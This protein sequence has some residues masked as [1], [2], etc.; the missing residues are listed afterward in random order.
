MTVKQK[1]CLLAYLGYYSASIDGLWG[2]QSAAATKAF[3][4]DFDLTPDEIFGPK[5]ESRIKEVIYKDEQ[6][7]MDWD[8]V[9][10]FRREEFQCHCGGKYCNGY[11]AE[12]KKKLLVVADR[13]REHF[14][15]AALVSSGARCETH[16]KNVGGVTNSRHLVGKAMDFCIRGKTAAEVLEYVQQQPEIRYAY[17]CDSL[18]IHMDIQ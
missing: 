9:K 5:T 1:Q 18:Y 14:G 3:Q 13:V 4:E 17:A 6:P 7:A 12:M 10:Y 11:P 15:A 2:P 16:N 8:K